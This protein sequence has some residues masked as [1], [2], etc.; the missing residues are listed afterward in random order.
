MSWWDF[1]LRLIE[2]LSGTNPA[3]E[4]APVP[5]PDPAPQ[6]APT[7][8]DEPDDPPPET[9]QPVRPRVLLVIYDPMIPSRGGRR[10]TEVR[11]W[12]SPDDLS[13]GY[14]ADLKAA[15]HDYLDYNIVS[16]EVVDKLPV[17]I[18]GFQYDPDEYIA[19]LEAG[20]GFHQPDGVDYDAILAEFDIVE[21]INN[22]QIDEVWMFGPPYAGFYESVMAGPNSFWCNA[23]PLSDVP[24]DHRFIMMGFSYERGV[25][26]MLESVGHRAESIMEYVYR[27]IRSDSNLWKKFIRCEKTHPGK[28]EVGNVHFAPN[29]RHD[30]DWG[31]TEMVL[32]RCDSWLNFPDLSG[33]ARLVNAQEWGGGNTRQH[34]TWWLRHFPHAPGR[35]RGILNNWWA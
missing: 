1:I 29:S 28:A 6:P 12:N 16:V 7:P 18:D 10:L 20:A 14:I 24:S 27:H 4:P 34:H 21:K 32:S 2:G 8:A 5:E 30:Y 17:K 19:L 22:D 26:E 25:G 9:V 31:N 23:P 11:G 35:S 13:S 15:S 3:P 33:D